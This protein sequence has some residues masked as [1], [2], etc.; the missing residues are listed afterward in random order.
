MPLGN[1]TVLGDTGGAGYDTVYYRATLISRTD[2][3]DR[4]DEL[5]RIERLAIADHPQELGCGAGP[6]GRRIHR[7]CRDLAS[8]L[9]DTDAVVL[10]LVNL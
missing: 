8:I 7:G 4:S 1:Q 3:P 2:H 10:N 9:I 6:S 5:P